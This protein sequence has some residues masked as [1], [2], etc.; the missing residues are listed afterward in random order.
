MTITVDTGSKKININDIDAAY[1]VEQISSCSG[2]GCY[3]ENYD[4]NSWRKEYLLTKVRDGVF[5]IDVS[6][7]REK[8]M[9]ILKNCWKMEI[10]SDGN[11]KN[12]II[13]VRIAE[14]SFFA[15][16]T[17]DTRNKERDEE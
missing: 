6:I 8:A 3:P 2:M 11:G 13:P 15:M 9:F 16:A 17:I 12:G 1:I 10:G 4:N 5:N 14:D 7:D